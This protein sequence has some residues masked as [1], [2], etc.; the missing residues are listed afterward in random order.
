MTP[1]TV[2]VWD[3]AN[4]NLKRVSVMVGI[5]DGQQSEIASN[6]LQPNAQ[7]VTGIIIPLSLRP[8]NGGNPLM[9][10]QPR[11]G[12]PGGMQPGGGGRGGGGGGGRGG[13]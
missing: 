5:T 1:G 11:G 4:K 6:D 3:E 7:I 2:Y 12:G 13:N 8:T 9:G 10:N